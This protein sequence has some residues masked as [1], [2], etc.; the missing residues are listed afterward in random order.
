MDSYEPTTS[1]YSVSELTREIK[2]LLEEGF[3]AVWLQGEISNFVHH[4]SGHMY[5][6]LKDSEAQIS[7]VMWRQRNLAL[8]FTP[9]DGMSVQAFGQVRVYEKRGNYQF[10]VLKM[11]PVGVGDLQRAFEKLKARLA[12]EG[13]FDEEHKKDIP[14]FPQ[15]V[16]VIT[17]PTGAAV[18]DIVRIIQRRMPSTQIILRPTVVQGQEAAKDISNAIR[19]FNEYGKAEVLIV[20]R[21]GGSLEDLWAFN[22]ETVARAI[23]ASRIPIVSAVGHEIDFTIADFVADLRAATPSAAAE[24]VTPVRE[25]LLE[26]V[27]TLLARC[28]QNIIRS[29][30]LRR[31]RLQRMSSHYGLRRPGDL[32]LQKRQRLDELSMRMERSLL[33]RL[34]L[35][36]QKVMHHQQLIASLGPES[37]LKRGYAICLEPDSGA[38]ITRVATLHSGD[39]VRVAMMDGSWLG[40]VQKTEHGADQQKRKTRNRYE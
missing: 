3:P 20:G 21:G 13:L 6:S 18:R 16:G 24:L 37:V 9:A 1:L 11:T 25:D 35:Q 30:R 17:S 29:L 36:R 38:A 15:T 40:S 14:A 32:I 34:A 7:V 5:F 28:H 19:E 10:D 23:Y 2:Y 31:E 26:T 22:E 33:Q 39:S 8:S 12:A 4:S 27:Q